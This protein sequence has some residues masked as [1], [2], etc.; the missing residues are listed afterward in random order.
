[1]SLPTP[2]LDD[3][4]VSEYYRVLTAPQPPVGSAEAEAG[5]GMARRPEARHG[6]SQVYPC[7]AALQQAIDALLVEQVVHF[8]CIREHGR[9]TR[10]NQY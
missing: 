5:A 7:Q 3:A 8:A 1:M 2:A 6:P 4:L 9:R 10:D